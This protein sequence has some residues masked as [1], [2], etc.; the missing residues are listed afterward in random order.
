MSTELGRTGES[1]AA[2]WLL[3]NNYEILARNFYS[4]SGEIDII[5]RSKTTDIHFIEV[6]TYTKS[7]LHPL[8]AITKTKQRKIK[9]T[10]AYYLLKNKL[11]NSP[12]QF[13]AIT[14]QYEHIDYYP[15][16]FN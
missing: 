8:E 6:K 5:A 13:D 12:C 1:K 3:E 11:N 16:I 9:K 15:D 2:S 14:I 7:Y 10:A 4:K